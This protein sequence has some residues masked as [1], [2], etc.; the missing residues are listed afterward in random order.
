MN[1]AS[2]CADALQR[3]WWLPQITLACVAL[4]PLA[5]ALQGVAAVHRWWVTRRANPRQALPVPVLVVGNLIVGGAGKTP[6]VIALLDALRLAGWRP[7][8]VSRGHG[9][10]SR[11]LVHVDAGTPAIDCGDEPLLIRKR[12]GVP[13]TVG[14][15]RLAAAHALLD[16]HPEVNLLV[17]DDG[18]QHWRLPRDLQ[19][20]VFDGRGAGNGATLPAGPLRQAMPAR[21][22]PKTLVLYNAERPSTPLPGHLALRQLSGA[23]SLADWWRGEPARPA[24]LADLA[25]ASQAAPLLAAAGLGQPERFFQMLSA[26]GVR[27]QPLPLPDHAAF[28]PLPWPAATPDVLVTEKDAAKLRPDQMGTTRVWVVALDFRLP[29]DFMAALQ[30]ALADSA[31]TLRT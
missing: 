16:A 6:T 26:A 1:L 2:R 9:R 21:V 17:C 15:D 13:V 5:G 31:K 27:V 22:P 24:C 28:T 10:N 12:S 3:R 29:A 4:L 30:N 19:V 11:G 14:A 18:L 25:R 7:G 8:V 23:V 20:L